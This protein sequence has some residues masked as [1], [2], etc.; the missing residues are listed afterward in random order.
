MPIVYKI[1]VIAALKAA[2][3]ST[4]RIRKEKLLGEATLQRL[5]NK[6]TVSWENIATICKLL[7]CQPGDLMEYM[8]EQE[9]DKE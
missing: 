4:Y 3:Y 1:D 2:G 9:A 7:N 6:D 8:E 5:R